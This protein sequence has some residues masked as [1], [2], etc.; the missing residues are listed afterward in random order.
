LLDEL[1]NGRTRI[2]VSGDLDEYR[3][4]ELAPCPVDAYGVGTAVV[5]GSG[6][7][8]GLLVY[9]L[10]ARSR[11]EGD[12]ELVPVAKTSVGKTGVAGRKWAWRRLDD[13]G[14]AVEEIT[15]REPASPPGRVRAL[16][17]PLV[18]R[19]EA[20][21]LPSLEEVRD[22]H[23]AALAELRPEHLSIDDGHPALTTRH[24]TQ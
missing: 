7:P 4:A 13:D 22:F 3:L 21:P 20:R 10:V 12:D 14:F 17:V 8:T 24:E 6:A 18:E 16:Q 19:G 11:G 5:T 15:R 1:G 9:K 2:V 23:G